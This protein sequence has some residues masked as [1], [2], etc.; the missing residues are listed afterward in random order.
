MI[1]HPGVAGFAHI[2]KTTPL[3][4]VHCMRSR[5][6]TI[7]TLRSF[8]AAG[9]TYRWR[10]TILWREQPMRVSGIDHI[11]LTVRDLEATRRFYER[12]LG[13]ETRVMANGRSALHFGRQKINL[14]RA[15]SEVEPRATSPAP[16]CADLCF[17]IHSRI[18][19]A[20]DE[21]RA[22]GVPI[23]EG[24]VQRSGA[25]GEMVSVYFNDPDGNL[26]EVSSYDDEAE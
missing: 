18:S 22:L 25:L 11:V 4:A 1:G 9:A 5:C 6:R 20:L 16:G 17:V 19:D 24:P 14:H 8:A 15:G 3:A 7:H 23:I 10:S 21:L 26:V 12:V 13:M 2:S